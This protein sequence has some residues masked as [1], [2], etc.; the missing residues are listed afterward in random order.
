M[1]TFQPSPS[2]TFDLEYKIAPLHTISCKSYMKPTGCANSVYV[3]PHCFA[4]V[5]IDPRQCY[6]LHYHAPLPPDLHIHPHCVRLAVIHGT[7][8]L[9]VW[10]RDN[11]PS[12]NLPHFALNYFHNPCKTSNRNLHFA[13]KCL[14][15]LHQTGIILG[16]MRQIR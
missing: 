13:L 12:L 9:M 10:Q 4:Q 3:T 15:G 1:S 14:Y 16:N 11:V 7:S 8:T 5:K 6:E 2:L